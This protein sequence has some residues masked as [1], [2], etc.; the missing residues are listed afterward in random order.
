MTESPPLDVAALVRTHQVGVWR[1]LRFLGSD[2]AEAEDLCQETFLAVFRRPFEAAEPGATAAYLRRVARNLFLKRRRSA[3]RQPRVE[4]QEQLDALWVE[5]AG[6]DDGQDYVDAL[7][8]CLASV[9][10]RARQCLELRYGAGRSRGE[11]AAELGVGEDAVK[12]MLRRT[13]A[14]LRSC[15]AGRMV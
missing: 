8:D 6:E 12:S 2:P 7:R 14:S 5:V 15:I 9:A 4:G 13:R 3:E 1:Y 11:I 10:G